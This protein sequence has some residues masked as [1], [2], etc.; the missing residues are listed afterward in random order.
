M[1]LEL[2]ATAQALAQG[3]SKEPQIILELEGIDLVFG[4]IE[5]LKV[6]QIGDPGLVIGNFLIGDLIADPNSRDYISL[7]KSSA[8]GTTTS[9]SQQVDP[10]KAGKLSVQR[11]NIALIDKNGELTTLFA[12]QEMIAKNATVYLNFGGGAHPE[13][14]IRIMNGRVAD[15]NPSAGAF[16]LVIAHPE[17]E[18][19]QTLF[20]LIQ[21]ELDGAITDIDTTMTLDSVDDMIVNDSLVQLYFQLED[22][23]VKVT[24]VTGLVA[25][26]ERA[27]FDTIAI[28]HDDETEVETRY[29]FSGNPI[30]LALNIML[31]GP[32]NDISD[33]IISNFEQ[34]N[35]TT[36]IQNGLLIP[37]K[38]L[39]DNLGLIEGDLVTITGATNPAN[40]VVAAPILDF[41]A[42]VAG[43]VIR[44]SG[45]D[46][47]EE[48]STSAV[49]SFKSQFNTFPDGAGAN[50]TTR[51][52]DVLRHLAIFENIGASYPDMRFF[53]KDEQKVKE[54]ISEQLYFPTGLYPVPRKGRN[55]VAITLPSFSDD[56]IK[57]FDKTNIKNPDKIKVRRSSSKFF[58]NTV[59]YIFNEDEFEEKFKAREIN[60]SERSI[61]RIP[62]GTRELT[63]KSLGWR[64]NS[65]TRQ[66]LRTQ[67]D[68]FTDRYQ[69]GAE[70]FEFSVLYGEGFNVEVAD[71]ILLDGTDLQIY[72][73]QSGT[74]NFTPR[75][76]EVINKSMNVKSGDIK[77]TALDTNFSN[78]ARY[79]TI[80]PASKLASGSTTTQI[81]LKD[82]F[83][84]VGG[85]ADK[86]A[87]FTGEQIRIF[88]DD[89]TTFDETTNLIQIDPSNPNALNVSALS[90]PPLEDYNIEFPTYDTGTDA[91]LNGVQKALHGFMNPQITIVTGIDGVSFTVSA[92]DAVRMVVGQP[93]RIHSEDYTFDS[94]PE[95][96]SVDPVVVDITGVTITLDTDIGFTPAAGYKADLVG[97]NDGGF[98]YKTV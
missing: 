19:R 11:F 70:F 14:S 67:A 93:V 36:N 13:D 38:S 56:A 79:G 85:E 52:V 86:W 90:I 17:D 53:L 55:S 41:T 88:S 66:F 83:G 20:Q 91:L 69:F 15:F 9:L 54:L 39:A 82:S 37:I 2:T 43:T 76:L 6:A 71:V 1:S 25:T 21:T 81:L 75:L 97:Y 24:D 64:D 61:Q 30:T 65:T 45:V 78:L 62:L 18:K 58:Y 33:I 50:M 32:T 51:Q 63:I 3:T 98:S 40:N 28:A 92:P 47:I 59:Q 48:S 89:F 80:A 22:E 68:R 44:L 46:L 49:A 4:A 73:S 7:G 95:S 35:A 60:T 12:S 57:T 42:N 10:D 34:I 74:R 29:E 77:I 96:F 94:S 16:A 23:I 72:D 31:S 26:V 87:S 27:Q 8:G 84:N 5:V